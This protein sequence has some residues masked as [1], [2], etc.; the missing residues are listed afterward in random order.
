MA[1]VH[2]AGQGDSEGNRFVDRCLWR[3]LPLLVGGWGSL[4]R[5]EHMTDLE[6]AHVFRPAVDVVCDGLQKTGEKGRSQRFLVGG[7]GIGD[8][9]R[10]D[11]RFVCRQSLSQAPVDLGEDER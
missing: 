6:E 11:R 3:V 5:L 2:I 8:P 1:R 9:D 4:S 10:L 7:D